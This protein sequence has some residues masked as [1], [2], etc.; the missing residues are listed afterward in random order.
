MA[1]KQ[2]DFARASYIKAQKLLGDNTPESLTAK[3]SRAVPPSRWRIDGGYISDTYDAHRTDSHSSYLQL[4]YTFEN[5]TTVYT[6]LEEYF[7]FDKTDVG[8]VV[9]GYYSPFHKKCRSKAMLFIHFLLI[10]AGRNDSFQTRYYS[11]PCPWRLPYK[12]GEP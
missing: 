11:I 5:K 6:R 2:F 9:G 10:F 7:S 12:N 1:D 8:L 3:I 4:G